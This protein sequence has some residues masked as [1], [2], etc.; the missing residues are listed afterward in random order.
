MTVAAGVAS[1]VGAAALVPV[2]G[3][4]FIPQQDRGRFILYVHFPAGV[5]L[6]ET[7][8]RSLTFEREALAVED[9]T[10]VQCVVGDNNDPRRVRCNIL[11]RPKTE[12]T[13]TLQDIK[14]DVRQVAA[15]LAQASVSIMDVS[16]LEG[17]GDY[18]PI[19]MQIRGPDLDVLYRHA[20]RIAEELRAVPGT[21]DVRIDH[22]AGLPELAVQIDR[23]RARDRGLSAADLALQ[24]RLALHGE[25]AGRARAGRRNI[26]IRVMLAES[27]RRNPDA[28]GEL[29]VYR[30]PRTGP[31]G[32][33]GRDP[34]S[35]RTGD[36]L[37]PGTPAADLG[38]CAGGRSAL[39]RR[40]TRSPRPFR[41][42]RLG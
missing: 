14:E 39:G 25:V 34:T 18:P 12:R 35:S 3:L 6:S 30:Q 9:V 7:S 2:L 22:S 24:T 1:F 26:D 4:E 33:C 42:H 37:S 28:L 11:C 17:T 21:S 8:R 36:H 13:R 32:R 40:G 16:V 15:R 23:D 10:G 31:L 38:Q 19:Q 27:F 29:L 41:S 5:G 20:E